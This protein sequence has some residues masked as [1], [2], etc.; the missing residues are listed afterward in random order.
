MSITLDTHV[1]IPEDVYFQD[2]NGESVIL[3][4]KSG[5]YFGL[6]EVGTRMWNLLAE[7]RDLQTVYDVLIAEYEVDPERLK[8]D[9]LNLVQKFI[10]KDL[11]HIE[12]GNVK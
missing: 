11:M 1:S 3:E 6:D 12:D 9:L 4:V 8:N 10:D 2:L 7:H 5:K